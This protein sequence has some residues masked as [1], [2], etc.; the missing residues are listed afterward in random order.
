MTYCVIG[1]WK[2]VT[3]CP[4]LKQTEGNER[5]YQRHG[6]AVKEDFVVHAL[7]R[8]LAACLAWNYFPNSDWTVSSVFSPMNTTIGLTVTDEHSYW[9]NSHWDPS[10]INELSFVPNVA[11][12]ESP[13]P[14]EFRIQ[15]RA[16]YSEYHFQLY[17]SLILFK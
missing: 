4:F 10:T 9:V 7:R 3:L 14:N 15:Y 17:T 6:D 12:T 2:S 8:G 5:C 11:G 16:T 13:E 1:G